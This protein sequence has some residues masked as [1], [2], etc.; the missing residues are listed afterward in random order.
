MRLSIFLFCSSGTARS[1]GHTYG[2]NGSCCRGYE[3]QTFELQIADED[4][5]TD[6][7]RSYVYRKFIG[8]VLDHTADHKFAGGQSQLTADLHTLGST[9]KTYGDSDRDGFALLYA[10]EVDVED[11]LANGVELHFTQ[12]GFFDFAVD[13]EFNDVGVGG[14]DKGLCSLH[15]DR[16]CYILATTIEDAGNLTFTTNGLACLFTES[17][18]L[19]GLNLN[20]F[21]LFVVFFCC[22]HRHYSVCNLRPCAC[23]NPHRCLNVLRD[24]DIIKLFNVKGFVVFFGYAKDIFSTTASPSHLHLTP[25]TF[26]AQQRHLERS[27]R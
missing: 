9:C 2:T 18:T 1:T 5:L 22:Y 26:S 23:C 6:L 3:L 27:E 16:E 10:I 24:K 21:H 19:N 14:V 7:E 12:N 4:C 17:L 15:I 8:Q 20:C 25:R 13:V 11:L